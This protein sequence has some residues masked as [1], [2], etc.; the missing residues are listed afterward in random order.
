DYV[1]VKGFS[2]LRKA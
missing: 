1:T 2:P